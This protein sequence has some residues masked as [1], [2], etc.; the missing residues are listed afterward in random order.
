MPPEGLHAEAITA[1]ADTLARDTDL[2]VF[3]IPDTDRFNERAQDK[4]LRI[5][6]RATPRRMELLWRPIAVWLGLRDKIDVVRSEGL[7]DL[8]VATITALGKGV[9]ISKLR[10]KTDDRNGQE[11]TAPVRTE[12]GIFC[13]WGG[14]QEA[15]RHA[16]LDAIAA[17]NPD[18][19]REDIDQQ[20]MMLHSLAAGE[21]VAR[22]VVRNSKGR[23]VE[24]VKPTTLRMPKDSLLAMEISIGT[25][26][27]F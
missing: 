16:A 15:R 3:V 2:A 21:T 25:T 18:V 22:E 7:P 11:I 17:A 5:L 10:L 27:C 19:D 8:L 20:A 12:P 1:A 24:L 14:D 26:A 23:W 9:V 13:H 4:L 6:S